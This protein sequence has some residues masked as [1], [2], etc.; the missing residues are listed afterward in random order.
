MSEQNGQGESIVSKPKR[1]AVR[2]GKVELCSTKSSI[3]MR[4]MQNIVIF[5]RNFLQRY[6]KCSNFANKIEVDPS[7]FTFCQ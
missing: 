5:F 6:E 7:F 4:K 1:K 2:S 3:E